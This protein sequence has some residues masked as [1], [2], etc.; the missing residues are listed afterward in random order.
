MSKDDL[1][2]LPF[3][4][5]HLGEEEIAEVVATLRSGWIGTGPRVA[6]FQ[7][8]FA[9][10]KG[11]EAA[12][13]VGSCTAALHLSLIAS[14]VGPGDEVITTP[15]TFCATVNAILHTGATPVLADVDP[16]TMNLDPEA[17]A[18]A[19]TPRTRA[20]IPVHFAGRPCDMDALGA[21]AQRHGLALIE[22]CAHAIETEAPWGKA[23]T[24]G[25]FG[26]F[27]F[28]ATKN[29]TTAEGGMVLARDPEALVRIRRLALHGMTRD[30]WKR[31]GSD[32]YRHYQVVEPGWKYNMTD[33]QAAL[34]IH[35]LAK[36]DT[37]WERRRRIW[38]RYMEALADLPLELPAPVAD[39]ERHGHHLFPVLV[40]EGRAGL[41]RDTF[42]DRMTQRRIGVGV[43]YL[44]V[45]EHPYYQEKLGWKPEQW[46]NAMRIGRAT[47]S[48]PLSA[49]LDDARLD[50]VLQAIRSVLDEAAGPSVGAH[51]G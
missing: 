29:L 30:A 44:S 14:G 6:R 28:Y 15:L 4:A 17:A 5:P 34:G 36:V 13:A 42:L 51:G 1:E 8:G 16:R 23:G 26:C 19:V 10:Y 40:E 27:S 3:G 49:A 32:G 48:L 50:R 11:T 9:G 31:F 45:A 46:P 20:L 38:A 35:Q 41:S 24:F 33:L 2:F 25:D 7:E 21:I 18:A 39:G 37:H 12:A 47:A 43:H 22:D